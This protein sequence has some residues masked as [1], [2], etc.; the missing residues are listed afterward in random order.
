MKDYST[1][2]IYLFLQKIF[3]YEESIYF[4]IKSLLSYKFNSNSELK[5]AVDLYCNNVTYKYAC[6]NYF[7]IFLWDTSKITNM[8]HLFENHKNFNEYI[9]CW[10]VSNVEDMSSMFKDCTNFNQPLNL[11][12]VGNVKNMNSMFNT[13]TMFNRNIN[14]WDVSNVIKFSFMFECCDNFNQP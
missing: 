4:K 3:S 5:Y 1:I 13:C 10:D 2:E 9:N 12:N 8:S 7:Y 11:W 6:N 14:S